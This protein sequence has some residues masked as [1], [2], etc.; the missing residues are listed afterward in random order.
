M[1]DALKCTSFDPALQYS[2]DFEVV[3]KDIGG[4]I[5]LVL[6][7]VATVS[8]MGLD[9]SDDE[10]SVSSSADT[11]TDKLPSVTFGSLEA[12]EDSE[13]TLKGS[14]TV[15]GG[16]P[17]ISASL[18]STMSRSRSTSISQARST[19]STARNSIC[20]PSTSSQ[21]FI[22]PSPTRRS[23]LVSVG[24]LL[25]VP[26][27]LTEESLLQCAKQVELPADTSIPHIH[28]VGQSL[29]GK[30][31]QSVASTAA[32]RGHVR[33]SSYGGTTSKT[34]TLPAANGARAGTS[35]LS[36]TSKNRRVSLAAT[37]KSILDTSVPVHKNAQRLAKVGIDDAMVDC[38]QALID[39][40]CVRNSPHHTKMTVRSLINA[41]A[42]RGQ[43]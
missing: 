34:P 19:S 5:E 8:K 4:S 28:I 9:V 26:P 18:S 24:Q 21:A 41:A 11:E 38:V 40:Q 36:P 27:P 35:S 33:R 32:G 13:K 12:S 29:S 14:F 20:L 3:A 1:A 43:L 10:S 22:S 30:S 25:G 39:T 31:T 23:S 6:K 42:V 15:A 17:A 2:H 7:P 16:F 37:G